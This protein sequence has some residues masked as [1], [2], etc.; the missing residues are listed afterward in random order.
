MFKIIKNLLIQYISLEIYKK[1]IKFI[2]RFVNQIII[3]FLII[4]ISTIIIYIKS[5]G[6]F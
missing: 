3:G 1:N 6:K 5:N 4:K 2:L